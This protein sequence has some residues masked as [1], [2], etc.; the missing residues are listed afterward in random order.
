MH[1]NIEDLLLDVNIVTNAGTIERSGAAP[2]ESIGLNP[3]IW[4]LGSEGMF[5]IIT[6]AIVKLFPLPEE[7]VYGSILFPT[8]DN[9]AFCRGYNSLLPWVGILP[10]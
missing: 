10:T 4:M 8:F 1:S 6:S 3:R 9:S 5:G 7:K 2:R